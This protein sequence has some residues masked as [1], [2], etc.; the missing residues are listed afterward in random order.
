MS[1]CGGQ[2]NGFHS[3]PLSSKPED[4]D[5]A[6]SIRISVKCIALESLAALASCYS[7]AMQAV[8]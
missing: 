5:E 1:R 2:V 4:T 3:M 8:P 6:L 7:K